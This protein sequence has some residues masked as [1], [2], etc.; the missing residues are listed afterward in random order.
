VAAGCLLELNLSSSNG[1]CASC[2]SFWQAWS[3]GRCCYIL[4]LHHASCVLCFHVGARRRA[5]PFVRSFFS[6]FPCLS[7]PDLI[8]DILELDQA[9]LNK[10]PTCEVPGHFHGLGVIPVEHSLAGEKPLGVSTVQDG[11]SAADWTFSIARILDLFGSC[12]TSTQFWVG[13]HVHSQALLSSRSAGRVSNCVNLGR[14]VQG[15]GQP[16][17]LNTFRECQGLPPAA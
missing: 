9:R 2:S 1:L 13:K 8:P 14:P 5:L 7:H 3:R 16:I 11:V 12:E 4:N 17:P 15:A 10:S 6:F